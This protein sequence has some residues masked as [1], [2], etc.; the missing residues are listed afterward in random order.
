MTDR[1]MFIYLI[2]GNNTKSHFF[3][4]VT[5]EGSDIPFYITFL[6][7]F[8]I[9]YGLENAETIYLNRVIWE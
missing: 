5:L 2:H 7:T 4:C 3:N 6:T 9:E 8:I 1:I